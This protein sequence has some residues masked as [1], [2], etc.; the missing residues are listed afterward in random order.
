MKRLGIKYQILLVTLIPVFLI[1]VFITYASFNS[2]IEQASELL[3]IRGQTIA[4]QIAGASESNLKSGELHKIQFLLDQSIDTNSIVQAAVFSQGELMAKSV[5]EQY[6]AKDLSDYFYFRQP[7]ESHEL[8]K[9]SAGTAG[10]S[11]TLQTRTIGW[12]HILMSSQ[13]LDATRTRITR[14]SILFFVIVLLLAMV[15]TSIISRRITQPIDSLIEH[16]KQVE[17]GRLGETIEVVTDNEIGALQ[18]GFNRMTRALLSNRKQL[19][20]RVQQATLQLSDANISME[21]KNRE[22]GFARDEAQNANRIK[23]E[24]LANMSH[25]IRTPINAIKGFMSLMSRSELNPTQKKYTDIVLKSTDDL[26]SIINEILDFSKME[27][28]K[29]A[30]VEEEFDLHEVLEQ[31][32]DILFINIL[33]KAIDLNLVIYSDTPRTVCGDRLRI[34]QI[35]LNLIGNAI[36]FTDQGGVVVRVSLEQ[37]TPSETG[38]L[39]SIED[40]GIGISKQDQ[41][42]LF[43]AFSQVDTAANRRF[44]GTGL[45]LVISQKLANLIGGNISLESEVGKGSVFSLHL[46]LRISHPVP[47]SADVVVSKAQTALIFGTHKTCLQE[48]QTLFDRAGIANEPVLLVHK[49]AID[50]VREHILRNQNQVDYIVFDFRHF[51]LDLSSIFDTALKTRCIAMHYDLHLIPD[52]SCQGLEFISVINSASRLQKIL[53]RSVDETKQGESSN[54]FSPTSGTVKQVLIVDDNQVNLELASELIRIWGHRVSAASHAVEAMKLYQNQNFDLIILDIQMPDIDG[55]ALMT[56]MREARPDDRTPIVALTANVLNHEPERLL[57]LGFDHFLSKPIDEEKF[58]LLLDGSFQPPDRGA[59]ELVKA[60]QNSKT[61]AV[62]FQQSLSLCAFKESLLDK[63][64][65]TLLYEIPGHQQQL[66]THLEQSDYVKL[67]ATIHKIHGT[68][69]YTS[70]PRLRKQVISIQQ[71]L[72]QKSYAQVDIAVESVILEFDEIRQQVEGYL[73]DQATWKQIGES[74]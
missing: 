37:Q 53:D 39:I 19:N 24:F 45:G 51:D 5:S 15:L 28:G 47:A 17:T 52:S 7:I 2:N 3:Q 66:S 35:L 27:S 59:D 25:E 6:R 64:F 49:Q 12:A 38:I 1:D 31:S 36:K 58:R 54:S 21:S 48:I 30:I 62:D 56:M 9:A 33:Q 18:E 50:Q 4:K 26:T 10:Q 8:A 42:G 22:L 11:A 34:K 67:S 16:L 74:I 13:Q 73:R 14:D 29:L 43:T 69:C 44:T 46:P 65:E 72:G 32:R 61:L 70:L 20:D 23:S 68:T 57:G 63:M 41:A 40:T 60:E 55:I 71:Q